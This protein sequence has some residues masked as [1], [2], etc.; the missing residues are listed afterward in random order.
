MYLSI[1]IH[2][3]LIYRLVHSCARVQ[4][5]EE[6]KQAVADADAKDAELSAEIEARSARF[7]TLSAQIETTKEELSLEEGPGV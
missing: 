3:V 5:A 6:K 2:D 1:C 4:K 7:G